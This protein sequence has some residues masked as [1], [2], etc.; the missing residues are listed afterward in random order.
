[1]KCGVRLCPAFLSVTPRQEVMVSYRGGGG[2]LGDACEPPLGGFLPSDCSVH[3]PI[4]C[5][6]HHAGLWSSL[7]EAHAWPS[8]SLWREHAT[9]EALEF[10]PCGY[11]DDILSPFAA[12]MDFQSW[13]PWPFVLTS[14]SLFCLL[15][16]I[17]LPHAYTGDPAF[18]TP[19]KVVVLR[20]FFRTCA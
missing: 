6:S 3:P 20:A 12:E 2:V 19:G 13:G 1:M 11:E 7:L 4:P 15:R 18:L 14:C 5:V 16:P 10:G 17:P 9:E 8:A